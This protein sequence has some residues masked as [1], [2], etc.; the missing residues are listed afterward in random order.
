L[1]HELVGKSAS[2]RNNL[3]QYHRTA[4]LHHDEPGQAVLI[5]AI[6]RNYLSH[7]LYDQADKF[8]LNSKFP[9]SR[10]NSQHS[11][12]LYYVGKINTVQLHYTDAFNNLT[13]A[14]RK[15]PTHGAIGFRQ[16]AHKLLV[17]VQLLMGEIPDRTIFRQNDLRRSLKPYFQL[18]Q[19]V[20]V[21]NLSAFNEISSKYEKIFLQ[22]KMNTLIVRLRHNVI[23]TGLRR[24]NVSYS[25]ISIKDICQK[26][27]LDSEEDA[28][29]IVAKA[30]RDGVIDAVVDRKFHFL[31]SKENT[32]VYSTNEP[33]MA[34]HKR[35]NFCMDIHNSA[36]K[37]LRFPP[38]AHK[39]KAELEK[40]DLLAEIADE[41][42][43]EVTKED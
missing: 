1:T 34:F 40:D 9:E 38:D 32:D 17:I 12:Y 19:A 31:Y 6:V 28:E 43:T 23:K 5:N 30:I 16:Q 14:I 11:R 7:N 27:H 3:L 4:C 25:K 33:Q 26:L 35:I 21:G 8:R 15:A 2:I 29:S 42:S 24:I 39:P 36:V 10:S 13:Q 18:T 41:D 20:R 22:D 37:D